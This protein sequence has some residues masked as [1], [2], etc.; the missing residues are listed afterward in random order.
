MHHFISDLNKVSSFYMNGFTQIA[1]DISPN[2]KERFRRLG[3]RVSD[4]S[5]L[6]PQAGYVQPSGVYQLVAQKESIQPS[7][8]IE[9][10]TNEAGEPEWKIING[11]SDPEVDSV[12]SSKQDVVEDDMEGKESKISIVEVTPVDPVEQENKVETK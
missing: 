2:L 12:V 11:K 3:Y 8:Q 1:S 5:A 6:Q 9:V 10:I 4:N 7:P